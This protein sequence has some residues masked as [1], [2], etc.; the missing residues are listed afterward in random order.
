MAGGRRVKLERKLWTR[1]M[2]LL[3]NHPRHFRLYGTGPQGA[4]SMLEAGGVKENCSNF[5]GLSRG[6]RW[7]QKKKKKKTRFYLPLR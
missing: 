3:Q 2:E 7:T 4:E 5:S 6:I 1:G